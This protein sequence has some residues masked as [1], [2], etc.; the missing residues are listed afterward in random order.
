MSLTSR[1]LGPQE[2]PAKTLCTRNEQGSAPSRLQH[3]PGVQHPPKI[4]H[5]PKIQHLPPPP[6]SCHLLSPAATKRMHRSPPRAAGT[7]F[8]WPWLDVEVVAPLQDTPA[9]PVPPGGWERQR[10]AGMNLSWPGPSL[11]AAQKTHWARLKSIFLL[12]SA[13]QKNHSDVCGG[14]DAKGFALLFEGKDNLRF[15]TAPGHP[16]CPGSFLHP[17]WKA[18]TLQE[19]GSPRSGLREH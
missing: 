19:S 5:R 9:K 14:A 12:S 3:P 13:D 4:Q 2:L 18:A 6:K 16:P 17:C 15:P 7:T 10:G 8:S 1:Q 11:R